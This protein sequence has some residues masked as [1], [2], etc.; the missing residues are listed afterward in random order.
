VLKVASWQETEKIKSRLAATS[1]NNEQQ[2][3]AKNMV[4]L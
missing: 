2:E 4:E 1:K 3:V